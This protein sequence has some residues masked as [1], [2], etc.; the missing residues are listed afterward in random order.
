[1]NDQRDER[2]FEAWLAGDSPLSKAYQQEAREQPP[3]EL[4]AE[5]LA[6][7]ERELKVVPIR[8]LQQWR[9]CRH[10]AGHVAAAADRH[11]ALP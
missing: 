3:A 7:A 11:P 1:M 2:E 5:V 8:P 10:R 4:D 6:A 9:R